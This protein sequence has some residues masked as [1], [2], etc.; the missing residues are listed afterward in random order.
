MQVRPFRVR[1]TA[2][3]YD[4]CLRTGDDGA[5]S[6]GQTADP[7]LFGDVWV[8]SYLALSPGPAMVLQDDEGVAGYTVAALDTVE[9]DAACEATWWPPLR[10][11]HQRPVGTPE[12]W[13]LDQRLAHLVHS[14]PRTPRWIVDDHPS[15]LHIDLLPRI[16]G[17]GHGA[18]LMETMVDALRGAGSPGVHLGVGSANE[19]ARRFYRRNG[20]TELSADPET[21]WMG[22]RLAPHRRPP[23]CGPG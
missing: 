21:V 12:G 6:S 3:V 2:A 4:V 10:S 13:T 14:P 15:H 16:Q 8:G 9:F 1:D 23:A 5:D 20:F 7:R 19:R 22:R 18:A 17:G 11:R